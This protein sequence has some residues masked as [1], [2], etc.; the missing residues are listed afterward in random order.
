MWYYSL[1]YSLHTNIINYTKNV[2]DI[3]IIP[4]TCKFIR[5]DQEHRQP[6]QHAATTPSRSESTPPP[7]KNKH[8]LY[9]RKRSIATCIYCVCLFVRF[10]HNTIYKRKLTIFLLVVFEF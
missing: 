2:C 4:C 7:K 1:K 6:D 10:L 8:K 3:N 9:K 5:P